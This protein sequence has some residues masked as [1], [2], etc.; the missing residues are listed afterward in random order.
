[1]FHP[2]LSRDVI[3]HEAFVR[4]ILPHI[5]KY[6]LDK[7]PEDIMEEHIF[8]DRLNIRVVVN[9]EVWSQEGHFEAKTGSLF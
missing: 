2:V 9:Y 5:A 6:T 8:H 3:P 1:M 7:S 4:K